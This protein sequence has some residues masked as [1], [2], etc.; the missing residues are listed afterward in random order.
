MTQSNYM[1]YRG[2]CKEMSEELVKN[3]PTLRLVR[4]FYYCPF[5]GEQGHWWTVNKNG[6]IIDPT[7]KQFP[8]GGITGEYVEFD[9]IVYCEECGK[10][11]KEEDVQFAGNYPLCSTRCYGRLVGISE[12]IK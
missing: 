12:Y 7:A 9:G 2:K 3:D 6:D 11:M 1:K 10:E 4:G 5:W 8:S